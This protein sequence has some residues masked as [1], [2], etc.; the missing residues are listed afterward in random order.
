MVGL[1][2]QLE[3]HGNPID[4]IEELVLA[5]DWAFDRASESEMVVEIAGCWCR[6]HLC[7]VWN[8]AL[9]AVFFSCHLDI[10]TT[11][12]SQ[13]SVAEL[14]A[15]V[16]ERL[17]LGHFELLHEEGLVSYRHTLP[18]RGTAGMAA[19]QLEDLVDC[20]VGESERVY[21]ALQLVV[22]GGRSPDEALQ[23]AMMDTVGE[24]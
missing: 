15:K 5:N 4:M 7:F 20:G 3:E 14:L 24:A 1:A 22:C 11:P 2:T 18:L 13:P 23:T 21:P 8:V 10:K 6:Y 19:D 16:N 17:W 12:A 9:Q